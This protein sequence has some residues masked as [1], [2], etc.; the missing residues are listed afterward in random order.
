MNKVFLVGRFTATP[1]LRTT[2]SNLSVTSFTL[3]VQKSF[4]K[5][6]TDFINCVAWKQNA[7]FICKYFEK[8]K[9][10]LIE[11]FLQVRSY[12][13]KDGVKRYVTEVVVD[14]SE[15][16]LGSKSESQSGTEPKTD[17]SALSIEFDDVDFSDDD[18]PF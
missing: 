10:I 11:G 9:P 2:T 5:D 3:A 7:E 4:N 16:C 8:G 1:E 18:I 13:D 15:F 12:E 6:Q 14:R 17:K